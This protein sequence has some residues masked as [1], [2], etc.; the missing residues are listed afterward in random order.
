M[1]ITDLAVIS[2]GDYAF[3]RLVFDG[4]PDFYTTDSFGRQRDEF[5]FYIDTSNP[6]DVGA[7]QHHW[8]SAGIYPN[9][10]L[11]IIRGGEIHEQGSIRIRDI[12]PS[13]D[14]DGSEGSGGW[15]PIRDEVDFLQLSNLVLFGVP[16]GA[17]KSDTGHFY[18]SLLTV[19]YGATDGPWATGSSTV[20][21]VSEPTTLWLLGTGLLAMCLR[22]RLKARI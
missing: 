1:P 18:W 10:G 4:P 3:F 12:L 22:R 7:P 6:V 9:D 5:Q 16:L 19:R 11:S 15:G 21:P 14:Q 8:A 20:L 2:H 17:I 13:Y